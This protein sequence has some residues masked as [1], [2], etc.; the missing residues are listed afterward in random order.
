MCCEAGSG[1]L[2]CGTKSLCYTGC[3][4]GLDFDVVRATILTFKGMNHDVCY[5]FNRW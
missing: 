5:R 3:R 1:G 2:L 4:S